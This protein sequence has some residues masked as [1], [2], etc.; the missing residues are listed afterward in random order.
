MPPA[1]PHTTAA[2]AMVRVAGM[3]TGVGVGVGVGTVLGDGEGMEAEEEE[4]E[5]DTMPMRSSS[6]RLLLWQALVAFPAMPRL[7]LPGMPSL[8]LP[9]LPLC[10][11]ANHM[12][13]HSWVGQRQHNGWHWQA[14]ALQ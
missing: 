12:P 2:G 10:T 6:I 9:R 11:L 1:I 8:P 4:G 7:T 14:W 13:C 5:E 3:V